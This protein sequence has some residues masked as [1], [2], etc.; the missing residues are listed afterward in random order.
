MFDK[1]KAIR[2]D[3]CMKFYDKTK[4]LYIETDVSGVGLEIVLLQTRSKTSC[5]RDEVLDNS[6]LRPITFSSKS[7]TR[8]ENGNSNI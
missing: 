6:I 1:A 3:V 8:A 2:K 7:V 5:H 4:P